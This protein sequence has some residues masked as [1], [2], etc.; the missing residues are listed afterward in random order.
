[1]RKMAGMSVAF[2]TLVTFSALGEAGDQGVQTSGINRGLKGPARSSRAGLGC[3]PIQGQR[4]PP[5][6]FPVPGTGAVALVRGR[7]GKRAPLETWVQVLVRSGG[8]TLW[9]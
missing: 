8:K 4:S 2:S 6:S 1:M 3:E 9:S 7:L 5:G